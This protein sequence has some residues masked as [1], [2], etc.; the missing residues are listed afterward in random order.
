M[1]SR[2]NVS[3]SWY[4]LTRKCREIPTNC[5]CLRFSCL[6]LGGRTHH[7]IGRRRDSRQIAQKKTTQLLLVAGREG[8]FYIRQKIFFFDMFT[9]HN[10]ILSMRKTLFSFHF[11][12]FFLSSIAISRKHCACTCSWEFFFYVHHCMSTFNETFFFFYL[13]TT[14]NTERDHGWIMELRVNFV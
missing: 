9:Q 12:G 13:N 1:R 4:Q 14:K 2:D 8:E 6:L 11:E 5:F 10:S 3:E 7:P